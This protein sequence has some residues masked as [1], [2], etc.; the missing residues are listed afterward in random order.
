MQSIIK[1]YK[2]SMLIGVLFIFFIISSISL[3]ISFRAAQVSLIATGTRKSSQA[4]Q[5][6]DQKI[7]LFMNLLKI[8]DSNPS[9]VVMTCDTRCSPENVNAY[10]FCNNNLY[11]TTELAGIRCYI[12]ETTKAT[13]VSNYRLKQLKFA[14]ITGESG[15]YS[16]AVKVPV[17]TRADNPVSDFKVENCAPGCI[18]GADTKISWKKLTIDELKAVKQLKIRYSDKE[19][20]SELPT[21]GKGGAVAYVKKNAAGDKLE[22]GDCKFF[23]EADVTNRS[24]CQVD[25]PNGVYGTSYFTIQNINAKNFQLDSENYANPIGYDEN[26]PDTWKGIRGL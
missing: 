17:Q 6:A 9:A 2:G 18:G 13:S 15:T 21:T 10:F 3:A 4:Y 20:L 12:D 5:T 23:T 14:S 8:F 19:K 25:D 16:R 1:N 11:A 22:N 24:V 7:E 26:N